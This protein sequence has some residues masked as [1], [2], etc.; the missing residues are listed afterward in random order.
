VHRTK[1]LERTAVILVDMS[2]EPDTTLLYIGASRAV[3]SLT[4][5]GPP[6]LAHAAGVPE[7]AHGGGS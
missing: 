2:G 4:L 3:S 5:V 6:Q 7:G 1:G